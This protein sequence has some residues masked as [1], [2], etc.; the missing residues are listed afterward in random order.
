MKLGDPRAIL[1]ARARRAHTVRLLCRCA[2]SSACL[3]KGRTF[4]L[5]HRDTS[6][7]SLYWT[8]IMPCALEAV[9]REN[10]TKHTVKYMRVYGGGWVTLIYSQAAIVS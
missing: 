3:K 10:R 8:A 2:V 9:G 4:T 6:K 1:A 5:C 7:G